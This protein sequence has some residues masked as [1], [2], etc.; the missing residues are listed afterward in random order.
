MLKLALCMTIIGASVAIGI[1]LSSK[2]SQ[3][4][5]ILSQ[6]MKLLEEV[7]VRLRY[8]GDPLAVL[9]QD[10]FVGYTFLRERPFENQFQEMTRRSKDVLLPIDI[11]L[12]DDFARDLGAGDSESQLQHIRLYIKMLEERSKEARE[13]LKSKGKLYRIIPLSAGIAVAVLLI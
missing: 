13:D 3:R 9:F 11:R 12:L 5:E 1:S 6:Y 4:V 2:L 8:T 10:N 7:S